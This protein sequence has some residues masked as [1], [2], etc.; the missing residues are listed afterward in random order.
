MFP[1]QAIKDTVTSVDD[2]RHRQG[3]PVDETLPHAKGDSEFCRLAVEHSADAVV[4]VDR[5]GIVRF[6]NPAAERLFDRP[7]QEM[8]GQAFEFPICVGA[9]QEL[10][11][12]CPGKE[13]LVAD[14]RVVKTESDGETLYVASLHEITDRKRAEKDLGRSLAEWKDI[15]QSIGQPTVILDPNHYVIATD[16]AAEEALRAAKKELRGKHCYEIFHGNDRPPSDCPME[17]ALRSK[18]NESAE[19]EIKALGGMFLV[20]C[21]PLLGDTGHIEKVVHSATEITECRRGA[22]RIPSLIVQSA[23]AMVVVDKNG[24][25]RFVNP[26]AESLFHRKANELV[27]EFF[28]FPVVAGETTELDIVTKGGESAIVEMR[29]VQ[30]EWE[31]EGVCLAS[32]RDITE[33]ACMR[34]ELRALAPRDELTGLH[35]R[36]GFLILAEQQLKLANRTRREVL[37]LFAALGN[38]RWINENLGQAEGDRALVEA[39]NILKETFRETDIIARL[40]GDEF[41]VL[42]IKTSAADAEILTTGLQEKVEALNKA[43]SRRYKMALHTGVACYDPRSPCSLDELLARA[44]ELMHN[45]KRGKV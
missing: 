11:I 33:L 37:L 41:G 9:R 7:A 18:S 19:I 30:A 6:V 17:K 28:R 5:R 8:V 32:L 23:D 43:E 1:D 21:T 42:A 4:I 25:V 24:I 38:M 16:R 45:Q 2:E 15:F 39:A 36:R 12:P 35:N 10:E 14:I 22:A 3:K 44:N 13:S 34:A 26:A 40:G 27:G 20:T 31:G 29:V